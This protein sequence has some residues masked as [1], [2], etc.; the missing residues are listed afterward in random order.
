MKISAIAIGII[1]VVLSSGRVRAQETDYNTGTHSSPLQEAGGTARTMGMGSAVIAVSDG[2]GSLLWNPAG[3]SRMPCKEAGFHSNTGL[4][5]TVQETAIFGMPLGEV[6]DGCQSGAYGGLAASL[7]YTD[8]G[9]FSGTSADGA[10]TGSYGASG[11]INGSVGY[12][13]EIVPGFSAGVSLKAD[14]STY[15]GQSYNAVA[16]DIGVLWTVIPHVNLGLVYSNINLGGT[17]GGSQPTAGWRLGTAW[18]V[19]E[20]W[21]VA[22]S[23]ELQANGLDRMQMGTEYLLG[24]LEK[25]SNVLALRLGYV[26][27]YPDPQLSGFTGLTWGLGYTITKAMAIDYAMVPVG[28]LGTSQRISLILKFDCAKK[29]VAAADVAPSAARR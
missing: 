23:G 27:N 10:A 14:Q 26:A 13:K 12:G 7:S 29:Q 15:A 11:D 6:G 8:Y 19:N 25:K 2:S 17:V 16:S 21:L 3:L 4:A 20:H 28:N 24:D 9:T 22:A 5:S 18:N 1:S